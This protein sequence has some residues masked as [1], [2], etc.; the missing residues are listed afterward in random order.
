VSNLLLSRSLSRQREI[1]IRLSIG[2]GRSRLIR[3]LLTE[4]VLLALP[5]ALV[6]LVVSNGAIALGLRWLAGAMPPRFADLV[7]FLPLTLD[8]RVFSAMML[9]AILCAFV[10]G[11]FPAI[12]AAN[13][14]IVQT[15][16]GDFSTDYRPSRLRSVLIGLQVAVSVLLLICAG[17]SLRGTLSLQRV[18]P[19]MS[20]QNVLVME[21]QNRTRQKFLS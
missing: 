13:S 11:L 1:G 20:L 15:A 16:R 10:F 17:V 9:A 4:S 12:Q 2:A 14:N 19:G 6:G 5:A 7:T 18:D 3:Q 8:V 21:I